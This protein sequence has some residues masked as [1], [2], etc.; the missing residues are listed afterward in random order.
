MTHPKPPRQGF[1]QTFCQSCTA[2]LPQR[3][4][5]LVPGSMLDIGRTIEPTSGL[6]ARAS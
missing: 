5:V 6:E 4:P 1:A 3:Q 2:P